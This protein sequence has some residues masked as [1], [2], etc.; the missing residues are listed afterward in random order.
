MENLKIHESR[1]NSIMN[2]YVLIAQPQQPSIHDQACLIHVH[3][4]F[5]TPPVILKQI[6]I[7]YFSCEIFSIYS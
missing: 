5:P 1:Q 6:Q 7:P 4:Y 3:I 2:L